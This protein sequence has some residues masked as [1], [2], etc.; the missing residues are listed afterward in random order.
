MPTNIKDSLYAALCYALDVENAMLVMKFLEN[1]GLVWEDD[2]LDT[3]KLEQALESIMGEGAA[4]ILRII[5]MK[6]SPH[7]K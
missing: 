2:R 7:S 4:P 3:T 1:E 5:M 6:K